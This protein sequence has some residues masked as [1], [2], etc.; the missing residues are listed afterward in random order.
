[1][2]ATKQSIQVPVYYLKLLKLFKADTN[3]VV[4][5]IQTCIDILYTCI[6]IYTIYIYT[7]TQS[8]TAHC[9]LTIY[10]SQ[11]Q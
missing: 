2:S 8:V 10:R 3:Q 6:Y 5:C 7:S 9:K 1:M 4:Y 11:H